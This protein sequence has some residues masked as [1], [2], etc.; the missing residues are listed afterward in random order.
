MH[1][2]I[3][4]NGYTYIYKYI[5]SPSRNFNALLYTKLKIGNVFLVSVSE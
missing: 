1:I 5:K 3:Q 2:P 4:T